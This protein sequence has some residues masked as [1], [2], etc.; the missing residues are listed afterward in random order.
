MYKKFTWSV[1]A[2][3]I[4]QI[5]L[6]LL[7]IFEVLDSSKYLGIYWVIS[8]I[9]MLVYSGTTILNMRISKVKTLF[10]MYIILI[11]SLFALCW[12]N[13]LTLVFIIP[14]ASISLLFALG[15]HT[16]LKI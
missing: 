11:I 1:I 4:T 7:A 9:I 13:L 5:T 3:S 2:F 16:E 8:G 15:F 6:G 12:I 14:Y 10:L